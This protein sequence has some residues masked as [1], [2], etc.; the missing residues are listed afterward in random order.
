MVPVA[1]PMMTLGMEY[2]G[3][4]PEP[5][6]AMRL[7]ASHCTTPRLLNDPDEILCRCAAR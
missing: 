5:L 2:C 6:V 7:L 1:E 3:L 4:E